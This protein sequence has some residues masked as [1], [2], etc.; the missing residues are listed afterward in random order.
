MTIPAVL[1]GDCRELMPPRGPFDLIL[2][3]PPYGDTSL[4]WDR[5]VA[6]WLPLA[7]Q[8][9]APTGSIWLFGSLRAFM[10]VASEVREAGLRYAQEIVWEKQNG[11]SFHADR[12]RRVHELAAQFYR[13]D[14]AWSAVYNAVQTTPDATARTVRRKRRP[15]HTGHIDA[16]H[17]VSEDGGP[18]LMRSVIYARN[19]HGRAIH[20]TEK[21]AALLEIL[22]RTSCPEGGLVADW[23]AGSGAAGEACRLTGRRYLGCEI[24]AAMAEKARARIGAVLPFDR[25]ATP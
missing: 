1:T 8:S 21:P 4:A 16:G 6:G 25:R 23:F 12:F 3:D 14:A 11:S 9:L 24:D 20:P 10:A 22:I 7:R 2:A 17:Y 19:A 5:R 18:R 15:P 13:A